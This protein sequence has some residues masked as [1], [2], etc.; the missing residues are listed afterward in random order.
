M[1]GA[2]PGHAAAGAA[3]K[4]FKLLDDLGGG[5]VGREEGASVWAVGSD[6]AAVRGG[7]ALKG[8]KLLE[9]LGGGQ[10]GGKTGVL[11]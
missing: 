11:F 10:E 2:A 1:E 9:D 4:S 5:A 7:A 3:L 8:L 6:V